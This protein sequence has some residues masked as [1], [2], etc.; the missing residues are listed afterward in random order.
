LENPKNCGKNC[1]NQV[2]FAKKV[3]FLVEN[4]QKTQ[5]SATQINSHPNQ[6]IGVVVLQGSK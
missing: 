5:K 2:K 3:G 6:R 1:P 4:R